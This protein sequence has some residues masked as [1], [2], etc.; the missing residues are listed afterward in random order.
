MSAL[1]SLSFIRLP[2]I[3]FPT[4]EV[5][6]FTFA[7]LLK[8][9]ISRL[10]KTM[11]SAMP[12]AYDL[13]ISSGNIL[14][15]PTSAD[16]VCYDSPSLYPSSSPSEDENSDMEIQ[17]SLSAFSIRASIATV[18]ESQLRAIIAK[19]ADGN[20]RFQ[21]AISKELSSTLGESPPLSPTTK[22]R[23]KRVRHRSRRVVVDKCVNCGQR[24]NLGS[25]EYETDEEECSYHPGVLEQEPFEF[26]SMSPDGQAF[27]VVR[28]ITMWS[29]CDEE[30]WSP[31]CVVAPG[32]VGTG[33]CM[34]A[35][36]RL[37]DP[38][39]LSDSIESSDIE[40]SHSI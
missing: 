29:C 32:H 31:G 14:V 8:P 21:R 16:I 18:S 26:L 13:G 9:G 23:R 17:P 6:S 33:N 36:S 15:P 5:Q 25:G 30:D 12:S 7:C 35:L 39:E 40:A 38:P 1:Q 3:L 2:S 37:V 22:K 20:P 10:S 4:L 28:T 34:K 19:L 27:K 11:P 24:L